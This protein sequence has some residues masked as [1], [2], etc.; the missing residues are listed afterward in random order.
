M[1]LSKAFALAALLT[2]IWGVTYMHD[3]S[4]RYDIVATGAGSGGTQNDAGQTDFRAF[5]IDHRTGRV[6]VYV[7][8][9]SG[10]VALP[11]TRI[12]CSRVKAAPPF[13][14]FGCSESALEE[15]VKK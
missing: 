1:K 9:P 4:H 10:F 13:S 3:R 7:N 15:S 12:P 6:W 5:I 8:G 2:T 14:E 11:L